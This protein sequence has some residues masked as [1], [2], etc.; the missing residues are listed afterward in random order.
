MQFAR[1]LA[2]K[3]ALVAFVASPRP[4]L[5]GIAATS[6]NVAGVP[7]APVAAATAHH[8]PPNMFLD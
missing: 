7:A 1:H 4:A 6:A 8:T 5:M 3:F 2:R